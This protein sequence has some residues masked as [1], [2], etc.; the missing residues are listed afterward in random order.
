MAKANKALISFTAGEWSP[1]K[2]SRADLEK[3]PAA[4]RICRNMIVDRYGG[5]FRR[6]GL[7]FVSTIKAFAALGYES[8]SGSGTLYGITEMGNLTNPP[9][10][11]LQKRCMPSN[12]NILRSPERIRKALLMPKFRGV[13]VR[14]WCS[15][16]ER[17]SERPNGWETALSVDLLEV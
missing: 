16:V 3:A 8:Y 15:T 11:T 14:I 17:Q 13:P 4:M 2:D 12:G 6:P 5:V 7:K 1:S 10:R 9:G